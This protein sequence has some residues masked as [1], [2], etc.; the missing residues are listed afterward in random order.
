MEAITTTNLPLFL[1]TNSFDLSEEMHVMWLFLFY[2]HMFKQT[3]RDGHTKAEP[4]NS[5]ICKLP[6][7]DY[8]S[9]INY[10]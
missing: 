5:P 8:L 1:W 2:I 6:V 4:L 3:Y 10:D 9:D 7:S